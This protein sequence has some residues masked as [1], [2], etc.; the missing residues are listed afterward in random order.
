MVM[1]LFYCRLSTLDD[2]DH[3]DNQ[4]LKADTPHTPQVCS[5][6]ESLGEPGSVPVA[7]IMSPPSAGIRPP[8]AKKK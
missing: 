3:E 4:S 1:F 5:E 8:K 2:Y 7:D 6:V